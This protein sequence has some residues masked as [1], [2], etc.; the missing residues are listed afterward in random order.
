MGLFR[1]GKTLPERAQD[2]RAKLEMQRLKV[3]Q[4]KTQR[5]LMIERR[6]RQE[7]LKRLTA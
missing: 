2:E 6:R 7:E 4:E 3:E 1:S 5:T